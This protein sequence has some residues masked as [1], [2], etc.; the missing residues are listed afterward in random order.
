MARTCATRNIARALEGSGVVDLD[1]QPVPKPERNT[2]ASNTVTL[3]I[4]KRGRM[5]SVH[6]PT[7]FKSEERPGAL[8]VCA[9]VGSTSG[10]TTLVRIFEGART[11]CR[12][13][14]CEPERDGPDD[15]DAETTSAFFFP[16]TRWCANGLARRPR[17]AAA[18]ASA[19]LRVPGV[20]DIGSGAGVGAVAVT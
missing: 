1:A 11:M 18:A 4:D 12:S 17:A 14:A 8:Q 15:A 3:T 19:G 13:G 2:T 16:G 20:A 5:V 10:A 6:R 9:K 7:T